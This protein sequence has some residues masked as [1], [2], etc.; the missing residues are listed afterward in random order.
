M[1]RRARAFQFRAPPASDD[2]KT[3]RAAM[4]ATLA[5]ASTCRS[6][7]KG[8]GNPHGLSIVPHIRE[9]YGASVRSVP[10]H[11]AEP[12]SLELQIAG[13]QVDL[14]VCLHLAPADLHTDVVRHVER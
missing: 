1:E 12:E 5:F 9:A 7:R 6:K 14:Q 13:V 8:H 2:Q 10:Q 3:A 11:A 4:G